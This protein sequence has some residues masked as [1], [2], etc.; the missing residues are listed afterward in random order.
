M[1]IKCTCRLQPQSGTATIDQLMARKS[2]KKGRKKTPKPKL[3]AIQDVVAKAM[4][5]KKLMRLWQDALLRDE[6]IDLK[7]RLEKAQSERESMRKRAAEREDQQEAVFDTLKQRVAVAQAEIQVK[8]VALTA[9][10]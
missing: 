2:K 5:S 6:V 8:E 9:G 3:T 4:A 7:Q 1:G 10:R